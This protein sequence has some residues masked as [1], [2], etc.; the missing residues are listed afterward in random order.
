LILRNVESIAAKDPIVTTRSMGKGWA[1]SATYG[2]RILA[3][4]LKKLHIPWVEEAKIT[5]NSH[6]LASQF[7]MQA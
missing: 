4:L 6:E 3:S 1:I 5:G 7:T 2:E